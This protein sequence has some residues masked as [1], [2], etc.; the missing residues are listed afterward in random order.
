MIYLNNVLKAY[1]ACFV[2]PC[3]NGGVCQEKG[4]DDFTCQCPNGFTG[5]TCE[6]RASSNSRVNPNQFGNVGNQQPP[7]I[8]T[9][10]HGNQAFVNSNVNPNRFGN[11][12]NNQHGNQNAF[13]NPT[14]NQNT[15]TNPIGNQNGFR[16][17]HA[18]KN[19]FGNSAV[20][21]NTLTS[22]IVNQNTLSNPTVKQ[23]GFTNPAVNKGKF[24]RYKNVQNSNSVAGETENLKLYEI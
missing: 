1:R 3:K 19:T 7:I 24:N 10:Q 2:K 5:R 8:V 21:Q 9:N 16:N 15:L 4:E 17:P 20:N 14:V 12:A 13:T 23:H 11:N 22:P 6:N 18:N